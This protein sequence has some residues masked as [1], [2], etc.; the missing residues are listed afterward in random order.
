M[1]LF[2]TANMFF[3]NDPTGGQPTTC[4]LDGGLAG[5]V[6]KRFFLV[7]LSR[8]LEFSVGSIST[9]FEERLSFK[10]TVSEKP[11][12]LATSPSPPF[13][14]NP[15]LSSVSSKPIFAMSTSMS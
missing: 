6:A 13:P 4:A 10:S 12:F 15:S 7:A 8:P 9:S 11:L 14:G 5:S 3:R 1:L 2:W